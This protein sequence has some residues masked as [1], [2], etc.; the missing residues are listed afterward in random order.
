LADSNAADKQS[1]EDTAAIITKAV[2]GVRGLV[3]STLPALVFLI[4]WTVTK[5]V[6]GASIAA[7]GV[8]GVIA[9]WRLIR[10]EPMTQ[11]LSG[12]FGVGIAAFIAWRSGNAANYF[13]PGL[14]I[15]IGYLAAFLTANLLHRP[16]AGYLVGVF[17][18]NK[19]ELARDW[20]SHRAVR[21]GCEAVGWVWVSV[22]ASRIL[23]QGSLYLAD[24]VELLGMA[25]VAM[26]WPMFLLAMWLSYRILAPRV[27]GQLKSSEDLR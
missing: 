20:R 4:W 1:G 11:V 19:Y 23:V 24:N 9:L 13:L 5:D 27:K 18:G 7:L 17:F 10:K 16:L 12:F 8:G 6:A 26:G 22:F 21:R 2:G 15:N 3:D 25:R 14:L